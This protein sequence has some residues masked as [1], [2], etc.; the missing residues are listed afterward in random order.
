MLEKV[1][2]KPSVYRAHDRAMV[3]LRISV[4]DADFARQAMDLATPLGAGTGPQ[5]SLWLGPEHWLLVSETGSPDSL[6][7]DC[8]GT[9]GNRVFNAVDS[10]S[11]LA[12]FRIDGK[13]ARGI[14]ATGSGLDF[15]PDHFPMGRCCRTRLAG[16]GATIHAVSDACFEIYV[17]RSYGDYLE[18]WLGDA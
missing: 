10:S 9:L 7:E 18:A 3:S 6:I 14:L 2:E 13:E 11:A 12:V 8:H 4:K 16:I 17:D 1:S 15:R 5:F